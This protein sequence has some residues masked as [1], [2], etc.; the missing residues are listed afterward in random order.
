MSI[1]TSDCACWIESPPESLTWS[2]SPCEQFMLFLSLLINSDFA[3]LLPVFA[4]GFLEH[5]VKITI[6]PLWTQQIQ[7]GLHQVKEPRV[8]NLSLSNRGRQVFCLRRLSYCDQ[9]GLFLS[10]PVRCGQKTGLISRDRQAGKRYS[11]PCLV[12][13]CSVLGNSLIQV[14]H[15]NR[16]LISTTYFWMKI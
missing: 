8:R 7:G 5:K 13:P 9:A 12:T 15:F 2:Y 11:L 10:P 6:R 1:S 14:P 4:T 3:F 16:W